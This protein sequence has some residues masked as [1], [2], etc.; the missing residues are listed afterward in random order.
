MTLKEFAQAYGYTELNIYKNFK[1]TQTALKKKGILLT[2]NKNGEYFVE[3]I[4]PDKSSHK[5]GTSA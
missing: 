1:R 5:G 3:H 2:K 4:A